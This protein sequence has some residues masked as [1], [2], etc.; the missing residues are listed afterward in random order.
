MCG[1]RAK[2]VS[3]V[4]EGDLVV[5]KKKKKDLEAEMSQTFPKIEG[6][7]DY[8]LNIKTVQYTEESVMSLLKEVKEAD[9]E[10]ERIMKMSHLTM[11]KMDIKNI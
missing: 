3:M 7:Y 8:L 2:F 5:F 4:I 1:H 10:L 9:E 6:N 11:W